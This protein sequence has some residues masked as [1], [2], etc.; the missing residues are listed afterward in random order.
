MHLR[1][2]IAESTVARHSASFPLV[3]FSV[4]LCANGDEGKE[5]ELEDVAMDVSE[6]GSDYHERIGGSVCTSGRDVYM[7]Y[8]T[9]LQGSA[10]WLLALTSI[11]RYTQDKE[12]DI[13]LV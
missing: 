10:G 1:P 8:S 5:V 12:I 4:T 6:A 11:P 9:R 7:L 2:L 3:S 13:N